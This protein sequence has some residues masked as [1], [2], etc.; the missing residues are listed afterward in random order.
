[1]YLTDA[2]KLWPDKKF[3]RL[4]MSKSFRVS[5]EVAECVNGMANQDIICSAKVATEPCKVTLISNY[6]TACPKELL[7]ILEDLTSYRIRAA[8]LMIILPSTTS[9]FANSFVNRLAQNGIPVYKQS[10]SEDSSNE[11][12]SKGKVLVCTYHTSKGLERDTVVIFNF[13]RTYYSVFQPN[14]PPNELV[15]TLYVGMTRALRRLYIVENGER[16]SFVTSV[17]SKLKVC[18]TSKIPR[19]SFVCLRETIAVTKLIKFLPVQLLYAIDNDV[20]G[21]F[22]TDTPAGKVIAIQQSIKNIYRSRE[23]VADLTGTAVGEML[24]EYRTGSHCKAFE[25]LEEFEGNFHFSGDYVK[26]ELEKIETC[27]DSGIEYYLRLCNLVESCRTG[28]V[29]RYRQI[30]D[31]TWIT[32]LQ[33]AA[34]IDNL[35]RVAL[36]SSFR[37]LFAK[38]I[39]AGPLKVTIIGEVDTCLLNI[40]TKRPVIPIPQKSVAEIPI[41]QKSVEESANARK[42]VVEIKCTKEL[43]VDHKLQLIFY[44]WILQDLV[45]DWELIEFLLINALTGEV[46]QMKCNAEVI[47]SICDKITRYKLC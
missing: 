11:K 35:D 19:D 2:D 39:S 42:Q 47:N 23:Y 46:L 21:L 33:T 43:T 32:T 26:E 36:G 3:I 28:H 30:K 6:G 31:Y 10:D 38:Q 41:P 5:P 45:R 17:L 29:Y 18:P 22:E 20:N 8:D 37:R 15:P 14:R 1:M 13:D 7:P 12:Y 4:K 40:E 27:K 16:L 9:N 24:E 34:V 25:Y 44:S